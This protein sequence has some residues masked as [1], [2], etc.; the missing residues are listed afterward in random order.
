MLSDA[1]L[2][3]DGGIA[4]PRRGGYQPPVFHAFPA[5]VF[6]FHTVGEGQA[7][8]LQREA[9]S[10]RPQGSPLRRKTKVMRAG[11]AA[12]GPAFKKRN[13]PASFDAGTHKTVK[14]VSELLRVL[15][16]HVHRYGRFSLCIST[17]CS[18]V[19][20][21]LQRPQYDKVQKKKEN[22]LPYKTGCG[23]MKLRRN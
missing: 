18:L 7:P 6:F 16:F 5:H 1:R 2:P 23:I 12:D 4:V 17:D 3:Q 14:A 20:L 15:L 21:G 9:K 8:P 13:A 22:G 11:H 10:G 19:I